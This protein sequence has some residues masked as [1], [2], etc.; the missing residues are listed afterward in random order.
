MIG[1]F[2]T[3]I[4]NIT[5]FIIFMTLLELVLPDSKYKSYINLVSGFLLLFIMLMPLQCLLQNMTMQAYKNPFDI[6][7]ELDKSIMQKERA[8]YD[9]EQK[10]IILTLYKEQLTQQIENFV[11]SSG[12][13]SFVNCT[14]TLF[15]DDE[16]FGEIAYM[17]LEVAEKEKEIKRPLIR[18]E[19]I[20]L[21][22]TDETV[23][24]DKEESEE[25]KKLKKFILDFYNLSEANIHIHVA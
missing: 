17:L 10:E 6:S 7:L 25:L 24:L 15:D 14:L 3:Y 20:E 1:L 23:G 22:R 18:I 19:K 9:K 2:S 8:Y 16:H 21:K 12:V 11:N 13:F 5:V 4:R